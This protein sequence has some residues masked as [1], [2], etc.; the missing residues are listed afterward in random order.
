[1]GFVPPRIKAF[2][3]VEGFFFYVER[4]VTLRGQGQLALERLVWLWVA[5]CSA[6]CA[7]PS[8]FLVLLTPD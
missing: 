3:H 7:A 4:S 2:N 1:M 6:A 8:L 5:S